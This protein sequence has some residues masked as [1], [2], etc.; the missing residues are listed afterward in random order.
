MSKTEQTETL[1]TWAFGADG[2]SSMDTWELLLKDA[3]ADMRRTVAQDMHEFASSI[4][5]FERRK[6]LEAL[7]AGIDRG[8][9]DN[10]ESPVGIDDRF[11]RILSPSEWID[12]CMS[13]ATNEQKGKRSEALLQRRKELIED[14]L[15]QEPV[16]FLDEETAGLVAETR[17][18]AREVLARTSLPFLRNLGLGEDKEYSGHEIYQESPSGISL[19]QLERSHIQ[20]FKPV[21]A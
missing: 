12:Y 8:P 5:V 9:F 6:I 21:V 14:R 16:D 11:A 1:V 17:V 15:V 20:I 10:I 13:A 3:S 18:L 7:S 19:L 2:M 4:T